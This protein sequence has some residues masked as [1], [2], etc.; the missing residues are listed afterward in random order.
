MTFST[1]TNFITM[2]FCGAVLVQSVRMIR[3]LR[4]VKGV[5]FGEM[6]AAL[7]VSTAQAKTVLADLQET[8][9]ID[10]AANAR[11]I[12]TATAMREELTV[13]AGIA[14]AVAERIVEAVEKTNL[15]PVPKPRASSRS[16]TRI[17]GV[18]A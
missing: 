4:A 5:E 17:E 13:M 11:V 12:A 9:R 6:V 18:P 2:L 16:R 10:C 7:D 8:L 14:D 1:L 3:C 15:R